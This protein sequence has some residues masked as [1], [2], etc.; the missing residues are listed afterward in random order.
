MKRYGSINT[1][2]SF[3]ILITACSNDKDLSGIQLL[4]KITFEQPLTDV[5]GYVDDKGKEYAIVGFGLF[6][7]GDDPDSG[8]YIVDVSDPS[9]PILVATENRVPGFD[10]KVWQNY[11]YAVNGSGSG[12]G[13]IVDI[14][15][16]ASPQVVGSFP[17]GHN[18]FI[19]DK[20]YM[21][22]ETD[23][24]KFR[25]FNLNPDPTVPGLV[26]WNGGT[27]DG[28]DSAVI[29]N[30]LYDF[31][32]FRATN[33]YDVSNP[34]SP[35]L[36]GSISASFVNFHHSGWPTEDGSFLFICNELAAKDNPDLTVW[37]IRDPA[38]PK[39]VTE[40]NDEDTNIH[41]LYIIGDFAYTSYYNAGFRVFDVSEPT[42][43]KLVDEFDTSP[44]V[45]RSTTF[46]G[47]FGAYPFTPSGNIYVTDEDGGLHVFSFTPESMSS[48]TKIVAP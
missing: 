44:N 14:K 12:D 41:N 4:G 11:V 22:L 19:S 24:L 2:L 36:L 39:F 8:I 29:G 3:L 21:Y 28:H 33:I 15:D 32:G 42:N 20:G 48:Q 47:A 27:D 35:R 9:N 25:I 16:P 13:G 5:W 23:R 7:S 37:D 31:A 10:V 18:M 26:T 30:R 34:E 1:F 46:Q 40:Y 6:K 38:D 45:D 43:I 17:S